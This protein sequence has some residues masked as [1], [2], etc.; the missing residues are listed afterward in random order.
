MSIYYHCR[1]C[2]TSLGELEGNQHDMKELG[3]HQLSSQERQDVLTYQENGDI[4]VRVICED[5]HEALTRN[6]NYYEL[7][8]F[9]Q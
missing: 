2:Q 4:Q 7:D 8:L 3:F 5:C 1:H 9:I 6:P